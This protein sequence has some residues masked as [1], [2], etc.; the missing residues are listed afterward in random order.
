MMEIIKQLEEQRDKLCHKDYDELNQYKIN[1]ITVAIRALSSIENKK[2]KT[3]YDFNHESDV[4]FKKVEKVDNYEIL[5]GKKY[6]KKIRLSY[7]EVKFLYEC[8]FNKKMRKGFI[9]DFCIKYRL[10]TG[11]G[12]CDKYDKINKK[13]IHQTGRYIEGIKIKSSEK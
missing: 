3:E 8:E 12:N 10:I 1:K 11:N 9:Q 4:I 6:D 2:P 7:K 13:I 5:G